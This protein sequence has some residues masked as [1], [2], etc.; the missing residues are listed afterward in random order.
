[1]LK[2]SWL[3]IA[4]FRSKDASLTL[5]QQRSP[6]IKVYRAPESAYDTSSSAEMF[7]LRRAKRTPSSPPLQHLCNKRNSSAFY[8]LQEWT[9]DYERTLTSKSSSQVIKCL[10]LI[11][12]SWQTKPVPLS[13]SFN[14][15][16]I[17]SV[18]EY[19]PSTQRCILDVHLLSGFDTS[20]PLLWPFTAPFSISDFWLARLS[21]GRLRAVDVSS[22]GR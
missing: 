7:I 11:T 5:I 16:L 10:L 9:L 8:C 18:I 14:I 22:R 12:V 3:Y 2:R 20:H 19:L 4:V 17:R 15:L 1:M 21:S 6:V 13:F